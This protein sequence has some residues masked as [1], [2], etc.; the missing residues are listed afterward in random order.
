MTTEKADEIQAAFWHLRDRDSKGC[1]GTC[2]YATRDGSTFPAL[3]DTETF[4]IL[5]LLTLEPRP[6]YDLKV[7]N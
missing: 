3:I 7:V 1:V 4:E 5:A 6:L 2:V